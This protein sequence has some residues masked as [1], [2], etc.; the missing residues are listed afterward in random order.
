MTK[1]TKKELE[2]KIN[3]QLEN[4]KL[5]T[6]KI[7]CEGIIYG[8]SDVV[9]IDASQ[10]IHRCNQMILHAK[11]LKGSMVEYTPDA[12]NPHGLVE[13][14]DFVDEDNTDIEDDEYNPWREHPRETIRQPVDRER[15]R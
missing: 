4:F 14:V 10:V 7:E 11:Q 8:E 12:F 13:P 1:E 2:S 6:D 5:I 9:Y 3:K 15:Y